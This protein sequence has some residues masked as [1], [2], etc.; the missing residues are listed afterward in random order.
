MACGIFEVVV[1]TLFVD[2][3]CTGKVSCI[4]ETTLLSVLAEATT[5][6]GSF[7]GTKCCCCKRKNVYYL[8]YMTSYYCTIVMT[9]YT[10]QVI[11]K[12]PT[13]VC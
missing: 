12:I 5:L 1:G 8:M 10:F 7:T 3:C 4:L 6:E 2:G 13:F 9:T 11:T